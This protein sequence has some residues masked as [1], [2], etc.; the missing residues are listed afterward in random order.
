M[1]LFHPTVAQRS[2]QQVRPQ[3]EKGFEHDKNKLSLNRF[4]ADSLERA[5]ILGYLADACQNL[6]LFAEMKT[7]TKAKAKRVL[8]E[9]YP[10]FLWIFIAHFHFFPEQLQA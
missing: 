1:I 8:K 3:V 5:K 2:L 7:Y 6:L 10:N 4:F 9:A